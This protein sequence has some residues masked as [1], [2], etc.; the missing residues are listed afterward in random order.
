MADTRYHMDR[1]LWNRMN[2]RNTV[3]PR[4]C[5]R[6]NR[7][8]QNCRPLL[9]TIS[10]LQRMAISSTNPISETTCH[11]RI[12]PLRNPTRFGICAVSLPPFPSY[13]K[14][15]V[16]DYRLAALQKE[17]PE[18]PAGIQHLSQSLHTGRHR[19]SR[20]PVPEKNTS[21]L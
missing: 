3:P 1:R 14:T 4:N 18:W 13:W 11:H 8:R 15:A 10:R 20:R 19:S 17:P 2:S 7:T 12:L 9:G 6:I 16:L 5:F 21:N